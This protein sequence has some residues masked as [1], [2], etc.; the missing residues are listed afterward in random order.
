MLMRDQHVRQF[1]MQ[2]AAGLTAHPADSDGP[3]DSA[4]PFPDADARIPVGQKSA[5]VRADRIFSAH[6]QK[7]FSVSSIS[8]KSDIMT[9]VFMPGLRGS[10]RT[11]KNNHKPS[12]A[13][14]LSCSWDSIHSNS[15]TS[16]RS[17][18]CSDWLSYNSSRQQA[19]VGDGSGGDAFE[20]PGTAQREL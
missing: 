5:A 17:N 3:A 16:K 11:A 20:D 14:F 10:D 7:W 18:I 2:A 1:D 9:M 15:G 13:F 8:L 4:V 6:T 12:G 19:A